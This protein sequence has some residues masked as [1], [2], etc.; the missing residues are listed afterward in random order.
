[1]ITNSITKE[2]S[3]TERK[4]LKHENKSMKAPFEKNTAKRKQSEEAS[5]KAE[6]ALKNCSYSFPK[7]AALFSKMRILCR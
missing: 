6:S 2:K 5:M 4:E 1:M 3:L 7:T